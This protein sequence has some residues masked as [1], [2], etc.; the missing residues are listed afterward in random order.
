MNEY[1]VR[2]ESFIGDNSIEKG[3][4]L[5][6]AP[7][8]VLTAEH[9]VPGNS[10]KVIVNGSMIEAE[11]VKKNNTV[12]ILKLPE[13]IQIKCIADI[14]TEDEV[15][16]DKL[17]WKVEGFISSELITHKMCGSGIIYSDSEEGYWDYYLANITIGR[18]QNYSGLSGAPV[19]CN[20]RI[21]GL[22]Q[23]QSTNINGTL[24]VRMASVGLFRELLENGSVKENEYKSLLR[25]E[26]NKHTIAQI[27]KNIKSK[28]YISDI[29]VEE[30]RYK[31]NLRYF[32]DPNLFLRK[33]IIEA[34]GIKFNM[35]NK[36]CRKY[37]R[38][39]I[40]FNQFDENFKQV[41]FNTISER[42]ISQVTYAEK[43][44]E[45]LDKAIGTEQD[46]NL[47]EYYDIKQKFLN[48]SIKHTLFYIKENIEYILKRYLLLT[49]DAG[50]GKTNFICDFTMNFLLKKR[51]FVLYFNAYDF[52]ESP[53]EILKRKFLI[54]NDYSIDYVYKILE[55]EY[56]QTLR[57][58]TIVIDGLNENT[59]IENFGVVIKG[60]LEE[61]S[62]YSFI[63]VI[64]T[65][66]N[67]L[68]E[69]RF[70]VIGEGTYTDYYKHIDMW[71]R[72]NKFEERI[73]YG[74]LKFFDIT[75][76]S[77]TL[78]SRSYEK[79]TKDILLLRF[80]CE[81]NEGKKQMYLYDVYKY[82]VFQQYRDK[83]AM[84][85]SKGQ[86]VL[87]HNDDVNLLLDK[88]S[89]YMVEHKDFFNVPTKI[90]NSEEK[91][92]LLKMLDNEVIFKDEKIHQ[93][94]ML[95]K[96]ITVISFTFDEFRDFNITNYILTYLAP[97]EFLGFWKE[98]N[99]EGYTIQ[100]GVN[101]YIFFLARTMS[102]DRLLPILVEQP[103]Y[104]DMYWTHIWGLEDKYMT[105][106]DYAKFKMQVTTSGPY[107]KRVV[108]DLIMKYDCEYFININIDLLFEILDEFVLDFA[109]YMGFIRKMFDVYKEDRYSRWSGEPIGVWPYNKMLS[110][111]EEYIESDDWNERHRLLYKLTIYLI[112]LKSWKAIQ[113][114]EKLYRNS[115][116]LVIDIFSEMNNHSSSYINSSVKEI[117]GHLRD[118]IRGD[119]FDKQIN[120]LYSS[121]NFC[122]DVDVDI[123]EILNLVWG[124]I[125]E[126][127]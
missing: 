82:E 104:E 74:Y 79:L 28:K 33:A 100:E 61:C 10:H 96:S 87:E 54:S 14:F 23:M 114:W 7:N 72:S 36:L 122:N 56:K 31:E 38:N 119:E 75:I 17:L 123:S 26:C 83:K 102:T 84:E 57:P 73:F 45:D 109:A 1:I 30:G 76:R 21:V 98:M 46:F 25:L 16:D 71:S 53:M 89:K 107:D 127:I 88:I 8:L 105:K 13:D 90:F 50:Q 95:N 66:R 20:N 80:F 85:Y 111:L 86:V 48:N 9:V 78:S 4:G 44:I 58:V 77:N 39:E 37:G 117:L 35:I 118:V 65:T 40:N 70:S 52:R 64:M 59:Y 18:S 116:K 29:F 91:E 22:L 81:V 101:K 43:L 27:E 67:E 125:D 15:L 63:K 34:K 60:F 106:E 93:E 24:G 99:Q 12:A 94:G 62:K 68:L 32:A 49:K 51:Y 92:L 115:P 121:N 69:E 110:N 2:V 6:I 97:K 124:D 5:V 113:V 42:F 120:A 47:A 103:E 108:R 3:T 41:D 19:F 126:D 55:Y 112:D 11:I